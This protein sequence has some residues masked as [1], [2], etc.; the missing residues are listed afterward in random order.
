MRQ[1]LDG[2]VQLVA[3]IAPEGAQHLVVELRRLVGSHQTRRFLQALRGH[4]VGFTGT[5]LH[6]VGVLDGPLAED[7]EQRDERQQQHT[8]PQPVG[9]TAE[10]I[11]A[12]GTLR[13]GAGLDVA[14]IL[15]QQLYILLTAVDTGRL[16]TGTLGHIEGER[17]RLH[18]LV[19]GRL[20]VVVG[21]A[22]G[23]NLELAGMTG[24]SQEVVNHG[25]LEAVDGQLAL[26]RQLGVVL[27][28]VVGE[29]DRRLLDELQVTRTADDDTQ[30]HRVVGLHLGL[31]Q[32][33][34]DAEL[35]HSTREVGRTLRQRVDLNIDARRLYLLLHLDVARA[36]VEERLEGVY[37]AV[38]L[39][40]DAVER[41]A[42][43]GQFTRNLR[44]HDILAPRHRTVRT[45][46]DGLNLEALLLGQLYLLRV[47]AL[48]VGHLALQLRQVDERIDLIGQEYGLLLVNA[49]FV[50]AD[51]DEK[52]AARDVAAGGTH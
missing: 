18:G 46:V 4:L 51:L 38:L 21:E 44:E 15:I 25:A 34:R 22:D 37:V 19:A 16:T 45:A 3:D 27:V 49:A 32:L 12:D 31:R 39:H 47:E 11:V 36:A 40:D 24:H 26:V 2:N 7:D 35:T 23:G 42:G 9:R 30:R 1:L 5:L 48:K 20:R 33:G 13:R 52:V 14:D 28:E 43:N 6:D 41:D 17:L 8:E 29:V 10:E 50:G